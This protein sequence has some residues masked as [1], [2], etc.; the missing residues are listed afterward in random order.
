MPVKKGQV[1]NPTGKGGFGDNPQNK[2][3]GRWSKE[4]SYSYILNKYGRLD[5][6]E[7][8]KVEPKT[9]FEKMAYLAIKNA[10][11]DLGYLKEVADRTEGKAQT[12]I[13]VTTKGE[14]IKPPVQWLSPDETN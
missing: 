1:I 13:D 8:L 4:T 11:I 9:A 5:L 14:S 7:F 3:N 10:W 2:A 6:D 12:S